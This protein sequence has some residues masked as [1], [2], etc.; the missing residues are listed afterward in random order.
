M[1]ENKAITD[2]VVKFLVEKWQ[3]ETVIGNDFERIY[4]YSLV[5]YLFHKLIENSKQK[6]L[7]N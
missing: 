4:K 5:I 3:Q 6:H 7:R 1:K 2:F